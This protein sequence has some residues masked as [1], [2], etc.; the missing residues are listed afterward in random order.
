MASF[1]VGFQVK[2]WLV[3]GLTVPSV[4]VVVP[5]GRPSASS[6]QL[7]VLPVVHGV[8]G[9]LGVEARLRSRWWCG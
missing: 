9:V 3:S 6:S 2:A 7:V 1:P 8:H 4:L 5:V